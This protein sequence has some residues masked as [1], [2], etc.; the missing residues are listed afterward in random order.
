MHPRLAQ[1][2]LL[3]QDLGVLDLACALAVLLSERDPL[4]RQDAGSDLLR[5]V[6]WLDQEQPS[7]GR[8]RQLRQ[9]QSQLRRQVRQLSQQ[10]PKA[11]PPP[12]TAAAELVAALDDPNWSTRLAA[13]EALER[14][15]KGLRGLGVGQNQ[16]AHINS[17][18]QGCR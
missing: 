9:L 2:L 5:R 6:D 13:L 12:A 7:D 1:L 11:P 3:G 15:H 14:L 4:N 17:V 16:D 8:R 18:G 10:P